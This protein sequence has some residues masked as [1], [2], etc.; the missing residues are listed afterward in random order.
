MRRRVV[1]DGE[2]SVPLVPDRDIR[3]FRFI[4]M[5]YIFLFSFYLARG[6]GFMA[7][8]DHLGI[9]HGVGGMWDE[10]RKGGGWLMTDTYS[11]ERL[12]I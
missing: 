11:L 12:E 9:F 7:V 4:Y 6:T 10:D 3:D 5:I 2:T 1:P 8:Y